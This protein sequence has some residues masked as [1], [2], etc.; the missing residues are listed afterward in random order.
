MRASEARAALAE[1]E[2][3]EQMVPRPEHL[4]DLAVAVAEELLEE[5]ED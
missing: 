5:R 2:R 1:P 3:T 4:E